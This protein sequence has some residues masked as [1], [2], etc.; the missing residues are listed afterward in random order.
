MKYSQ[1]SLYRNTPEGKS[2]QTTYIPAKFAV[3]DKVLRL[4]N[5][6]D[7]WENG[8]VVESTGTPIEEELLPDFHKAI[9]G[10]RKATGDSM[11][12]TE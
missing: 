7:V 8:W 3:V 12:R 1:C 6:E 9:R 4:K 11:A 5:D 2:K 10:H